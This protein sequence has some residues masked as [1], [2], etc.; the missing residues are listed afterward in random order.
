MGPKWGQDFI[1]PPAFWPAFFGPA[2]D[3]GHKPGGKPEG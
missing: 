1:L 2:Q 3:A